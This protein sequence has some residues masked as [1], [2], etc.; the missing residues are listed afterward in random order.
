MSL[1][2]RVEEIPSTHRTVYDHVIASPGSP[3]N[4]EETP[5]MGDRGGGALKQHS[6]L[7][8]GGAGTH[9]LLKE[10]VAVEVG[11]VDGV[12]GPEELGAVHW[13]DFNLF[14]TEFWEI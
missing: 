6:A 12:A 14:I 13:V 5:M 4:R 1:N 10:R 9:R 2:L 8:E 3:G 7:L 11:V